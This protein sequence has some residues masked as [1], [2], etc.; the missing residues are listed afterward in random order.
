VY[1][2]AG[3]PVCMTPGVGKTVA[4]LYRICEPRQ[5]ILPNLYSRRT[6]AVVALELQ[7]P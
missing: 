6:K 2:I 3:D 5:Q 7:A 1:D 4:T